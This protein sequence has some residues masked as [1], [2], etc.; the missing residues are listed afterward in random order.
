MNGWGIFRQTL[1]D[2]RRAALA[3]G[4]GGALLAIMVTA[5]YPL[6]KNFKEI[7]QL[8]ENPFISALVG[9][10]GDYTTPQGFLG[11]E[12]FGFMPLFLAFYTVV[13]GLWIASSDEESGCLDV[14]LS[15]PTPR[16]QVIVQRLLAYGVVYVIILALMLAG[17]AV[18]VPLMPDL[19]LPFYR[20]AEGMLNLLPMML[21]PTA[22]TLL[23][24]TLLRGR[25]TAAGVAGAIVVGSW[26]ANALADLAPTALKGM[27]Q[28]SMF[29]Y[30]DSFDTLNSGLN[31]G[32]FVLLMALAIVLAGLSLVTFQRRDLMA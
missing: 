31:V 7:N 4:I 18:I 14:L 3:I 12:F 28:L 26:F 27:Q 20:L 21:L 25:N 5:F 15:T 9:K 23:L 10:V 17:F 1:R 2:S 16:W 22:L 13:V 24:S 11:S 19:G 6:F 8:L 29:Y 30:Y 32:S